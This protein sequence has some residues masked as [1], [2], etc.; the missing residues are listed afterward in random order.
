M[1]NVVGVLLAW[2]ASF[3][4]SMAVLAEGW[5]GR[6]SQPEFW[7]LAGVLGWPVLLLA[8]PVYH[9]AFR[10]MPGA[11][12]WKLAMIGLLMFPLPLVLLIVADWIIRGDLPR[13]PLSSFAWDFWCALWYALFGLLFGAWVGM[14]RRLESR[15]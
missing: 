1:N 2:L 9:Q 4:V 10:R 7:V 11:A 12:W 6:P 8:W 3:W 14:T 15:G 5:K 13:G